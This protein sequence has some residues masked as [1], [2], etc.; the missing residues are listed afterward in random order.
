MTYALDCGGGGE[1]CKE[2]ERGATTDGKRPGGHFVMGC[3]CAYVLPPLCPPCLYVCLCVC[4]RCQEEV[5]V[6]RDS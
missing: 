1:E 6:V 3:L 2:E 4:R 5:C